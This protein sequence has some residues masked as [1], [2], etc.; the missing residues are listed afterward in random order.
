[1]IDVIIPAYNCSK[2]IRKTLSSLVAQTDKNF[3]VIIVDDCSSE[4]FSDIVDDFR[5]LLNIT[6]IKNDV[7]V[8]PGM[9]RQ[10]GINN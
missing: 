9:S 3:N 4:S 7:N 1:M 5:E 6:Y 8:G 2:T 10:V